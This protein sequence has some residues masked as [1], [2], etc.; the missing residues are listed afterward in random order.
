LA[1]QETQRHA[2]GDETPRGLP[3]DISRGPSA[4]SPFSVVSQSS[5]VPESSTAAKWVQV[6]RGVS[7]GAATPVPDPG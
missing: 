6:L 4:M 1:I 2:V 3:G 7:E 5:M